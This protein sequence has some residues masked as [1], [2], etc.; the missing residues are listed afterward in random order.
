M[1]LRDEAAAPS[2][3]V[4]LLPLV[5]D[6]G[7][8]RAG[9]Y[10]CDFLLSI[11]AFWG[12]AAALVLRAPPLDTAAFAWFTVAVFALYRAS[13][14]MHEIVHLP[15]QVLPGF[16][17]CWDLLCGIPMLLPACFYSSHLDHH[18]AG[19]YGTRQDP[20]YLPLLHESWAHMA[21]LLLG[22]LMA[23]LTLWVRFALLT[24]LAWC[25]LP[26]RRF[27]DERCSSVTLHTH[28]R[29]DPARLLRTLRQVRLAELL[30]TLWAWSATALWVG[31][32]LPQRW[33][34]TFLAVVLG[35][36]LVNMVRTAFTHHYRNSGAPM[37]HAQQIA[38]SV[39]W[40]GGGLLTELFAPVGLR[41]HALHHVFPYLPYHALG[42]AHAR[43]MAAGPAALAYQR[44]DAAHRPRCAA[45]NPTS[46]APP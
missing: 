32:V 30:T 33:V 24:P 9:I 36:L 31:G 41:Y 7:Q 19:R 6:L 23:P 27:V 45:N 35:V 39:T 3:S 11:A 1:S 40:S 29:A 28:H 42:T 22:T 38:D 26:V 8:H 5:R 10:W 25:A 12:S 20:E 2:L 43:L 46:T 44:T 16:R 4:Q 37:S 17:W 21:L 34:L 13:C 18:A 15:R 14:F